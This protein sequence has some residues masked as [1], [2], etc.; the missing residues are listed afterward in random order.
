[1]ADH[2]IAAAYADNIINRT[3]E[4]SSS[5]WIEFSTMT[6]KEGCDDKTV[7]KR[8]LQNMFQLVLRRKSTV[9]CVVN[10]KFI[11]DPTNATECF[12]GEIKI[13]KVV[14]VSEYSTF[15][16]FKISYLLIFNALRPY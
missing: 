10:C 6:S 4:L 9:L 5:E 16:A 8:V 11:K 7:K 2:A 14:I 15:I 1:M 13:W 3:N 12:R